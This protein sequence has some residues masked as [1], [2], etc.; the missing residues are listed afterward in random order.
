MDNCHWLGSVNAVVQYDQARNLYARY[1]LQKPDDPVPYHRL[2]VIAAR[3][4][5][6]DKAEEYFQ[7]A[8]SDGPAEQ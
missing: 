1:L 2:A 3:E 4:Q 8:R 6:Y 5:Q 7:K